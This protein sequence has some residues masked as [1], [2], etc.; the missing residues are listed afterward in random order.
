[1]GTFIEFWIVCSLSWVSK[2]FIYHWEYTSIYRLLSY[3][4]RFLLKKPYVKGRR[5]NKEKKEILKSTVKPNKYKKIYL[6]HLFDISLQIKQLMLRSYWDSYNQ[7]KK[8]Q[9]KNLK[10]QLKSCLK[11][12]RY[13]KISNPIITDIII[14]KICYH[15]LDFFG[16]LW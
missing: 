6:C 1:M 3:H 9:Q 14:S 11:N 8:N 7:H 13:N 16:F 5:E 4:F 12:N 15:I 2:R 10:Y